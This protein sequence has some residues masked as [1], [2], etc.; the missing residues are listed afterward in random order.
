MHVQVGKEIMVVLP[1]VSSFCYYPVPNDLPAGDLP[2]MRYCPG[3]L[4][5]ILTS[6]AEE[7][8]GSYWLLATGYVTGY[9]RSLQ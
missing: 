3:F 1:F 4:R 9:T 5:I 2:G 6:F 8:N 7:T